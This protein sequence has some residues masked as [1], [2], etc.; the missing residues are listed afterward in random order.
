VWVQL[1][2]DRHRTYGPNGGSRLRLSSLDPPFVGHPNRDHRHPAF[3]SS[4]DEVSSEIRD[5]AL[6]HQPIEGRIDRSLDNP[7][8]HLIIPC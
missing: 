6:T 3:F 7:V 1:G 8:R 4:S 2:H 5:H